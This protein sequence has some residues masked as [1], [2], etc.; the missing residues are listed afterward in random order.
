M[1]NRILLFASGFT[2]LAAGGAA[3]QL[4]LSNQFTVNKFSLSPAY[5]GAGGDFEIFG[6]YRNEWADVPGAPETKTI[7]ANGMIGKNMGLGGSVSS[8]KAG[9]FENISASA[10]YAYHL[11]LGVGQHLS[12]GLG[13][14]LLESRVN[15]A[16]N[17]GQTNDPV[18]VNNMDVNALVMDAS[19]GILYRMKDLHA[20][21]ALPRLLS[22]KIKNDAGQAV[23]SLVMQQAF[24]IGYRYSINN[25]WAIDPVAKVSLVKNAP[26]FY[27]VAVPVI[28]KRMV[29]LSP[30]YKKTDIAIGIGGIPYSNLIAQYSYEF[31]SKGIMGE[32]GGTHEITIGWRMQPRKKSEVPAPDKKKPYIDWILK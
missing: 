1:I 7:S 20:G 6:T 27:D 2:L 4:P 14:G 17:A 3:Q 13:A 9:V 23:Y 18:A 8:F 25:D 10:S 22:S 19:F 21:I 16:G 11:K 24:N 31:S 29:W 28:Y 32:S 26:V 12:F 30:I 5:A 15:I